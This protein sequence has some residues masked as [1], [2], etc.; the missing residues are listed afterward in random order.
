MWRQGAS[1]TKRGIRCLFLHHALWH[2]LAPY[3]LLSQYGCID[4]GEWKTFLPRDLRWPGGTIIS[5][6]FLYSSHTLQSGPNVIWRL[7]TAGQTHSCFYPLEFLSVVLSCWD[8]STECLVCG[9]AHYAHCAGLGGS[10]F[11]KDCQKLEKS[12]R[13]C[14]S[15]K[16]YFTPAAYVI[17]C[18]SSLLPRSFRPN[19]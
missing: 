2:N 8:H 17:S 10:A 9:Y 5:L 12:C 4:K 7:L 11:L 6:F 16:A 19:F 1:L 14:S 13:Q 18:S 15:T 3:E